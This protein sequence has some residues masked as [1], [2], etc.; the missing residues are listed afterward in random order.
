MVSV[1][2]YLKFQISLKKRLFNIIHDFFGTFDVNVLE[3]M[4]SESE[5]LNWFRRHLAAELQTKPNVKAKPVFSQGYS[6][7]V[8]LKD[9]IKWSD[10]SW[11]NSEYLIRIFS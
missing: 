1:S 2:V 7:F 5:T 3:K 9:N 10:Q 6:F 8:F 4:L 11:L